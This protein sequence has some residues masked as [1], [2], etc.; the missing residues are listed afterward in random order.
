[1]CLVICHSSGRPFHWSP[2]WPKA[3][4]FLTCSRGGRI[5]EWES[6]QQQGAGPEGTQDAQPIIKFVTAENA[7]YLCAK[8][9]ISP[10]LDRLRW[11]KLDEIRWGYY[12][13]VRIFRPREEAAKLSWD[14]VSTAKVHLLQKENNNS[15]SSKDK[16]VTREFWFVITAS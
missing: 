8:T 9:H 7:A 13:S 3:S 6:T 12:F 10:H 2:C 5:L 11:R 1:M 4:R 14:K 16:Q 15:R